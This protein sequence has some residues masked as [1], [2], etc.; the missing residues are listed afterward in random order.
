MRAYVDLHVCPS[1]DDLPNAQTMAKL[2][3]EV[4][5]QIIGLVLP[6]ER[7]APLPSV[8]DVFKDSGVDVAK[9]LNLRPRSREE[10]LRSL[11]RFRGKYDV[12]AVECGVPS[13]LR[14]AVRDR[15]VDIFRFPD[16]VHT[17]ILRGSLGG[18][19]RASLEINLS[20]LDSGPDFGARLVGAKRE[21]EAAAEASAK[22]VGCTGASNPFELRSPRDTAAILHLLG[23]SLESA[24]MAVSEIP[25]RIVEK[26]RLRIKEA[27][28]AEGVKV[29]RGAT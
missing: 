27:R 28:L 9:R 16:R 10:L 18:S 5:V 17:R 3:T 15:R 26:N 19:C 6:P 21:I 8:V 4:Q 23:L 22:V 12:I 24:S 13:V 14:V 2:L 29:L 20:E 1:L 11:R 25:F 7:L